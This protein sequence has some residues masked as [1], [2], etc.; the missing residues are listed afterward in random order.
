MDALKLLRHDLTAKAISIAQQ[1]DSKPYL[2]IAFWGREWRYYETEILL[3]CA[4]LKY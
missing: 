2:E 4:L 3:S 1:F